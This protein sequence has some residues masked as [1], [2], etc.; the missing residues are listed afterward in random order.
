LW[1]AAPLAFLIGETG[2]ERIVLWLALS[3]FAMLLELTTADRPVT[4]PAV[5]YIED[6]E[7]EE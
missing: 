4:P 5:H 2:L 7:P 6:K 3:A 1:L